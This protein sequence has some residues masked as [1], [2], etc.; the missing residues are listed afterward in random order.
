[1]FPTKTQAVGQDRSGCVSPEDIYVK[2]PTCNENYIGIN[3]LWSN[4]VP[5]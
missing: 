4:P 3:L 2:L 5:L 1:M